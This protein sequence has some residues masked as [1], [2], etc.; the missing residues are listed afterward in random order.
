MIL[1]KPNRASGFDVMKFMHTETITQVIISISL[2]RDIYNYH[3]IPGVR[4]CYFNGQL[5]TKEI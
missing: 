5:G 2:Y 1:S 4:A 3:S